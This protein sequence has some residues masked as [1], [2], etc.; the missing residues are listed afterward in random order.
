MQKALRTI[1]DALT[2]HASFPRNGRMK[3]AVPDG[4]T[5]LV[6]TPQTLLRRLAA[7]VPPPRQNLT[8]RDEVAGLHE[9]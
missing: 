5:H 6:L 8:R 2:I 9:N 3:R 4:S 7:L 1:V